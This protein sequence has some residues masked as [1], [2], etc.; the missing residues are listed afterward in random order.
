MAARPP[1]KGIFPLDHFGECKQ[2]R[3]A[4]R[5]RAA[6]RAA[7]ARASPLAAS[8]PPSLDHPAPPGRTRSSSRP[9]PHHH[10][11]PLALQVAQQYLECLR[12]HDAEASN[13]KELSRRYL[14]CR[15]ER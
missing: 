11:L 9:P 2:V 15:M 10:P 12:Q 8:L 6:L 7:R 13:C 14:E 1:E 5:R 4:H 3:C